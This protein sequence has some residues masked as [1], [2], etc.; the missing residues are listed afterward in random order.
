M[1]AYVKPLERESPTIMSSVIPFGFEP[2]F[3]YNQDFKTVFAIMP[4]IIMMILAMIPSML[5]AIGIVREREVGSISNLYASPATVGEFLIGKQLP[6]VLVSF[7]SFLALVLI[8]V[9]HFG[10]AIKGSLAGLLLAGLLYV[11]AMTAFGIWVSSFVRT[12]V[13][14]L[15]ATAVICQV[16]ALNFSGFLYP[17]ATLEGSGYII[18]HGFP[19]LYFQNVSLAMFAKARVFGD[20]ALDYIVLFAFGTLFLLA[21]R[22]SL[23]KQES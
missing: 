7:T 10:L 1:Q 23:K 21:A 8:A 18:G 6:Y 2:R 17:A 11:F 13:A 19:A 14:A 5:A 22:L 20:L 4:G 9:F 12:Q 16:P 3:W 15:I